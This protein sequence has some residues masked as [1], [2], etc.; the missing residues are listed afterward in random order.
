MTS[1][2]RDAPVASVGV[3]A[4]VGLVLATAMVAFLPNDPN[5]IAHLLLLVLTLPVARRLSGAGRDDRRQVLRE[6]PGPMS[7]TTAL[8]QVQPSSASLDLY[9]QAGA[10]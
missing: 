2:C 1:S 7:S 4:Y 9:E 6:R 10:A 3:V 5:A 8:L